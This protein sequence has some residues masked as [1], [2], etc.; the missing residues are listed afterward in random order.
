MCWVSRLRC[1]VSKFADIVVHAYL[2]HYN[3]SPLKGFNFTQTI[4]G[5]LVFGKYRGWMT[6]LLGE[7]YYWTFENW[8]CAD[9]PLTT[10]TCQKYYSACILI[11]CNWSYLFAKML[12][13]RWYQ[14]LKNYLSKKHVTYFS[15]LFLLGQ[16][17][18][19]RLHLKSKVSWKGYTQGAEGTYSPGNKGVHFIRQFSSYSQKTNQIFQ[20]FQNICTE[21]RH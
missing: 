5:S 15:L 17:I 2:T 1:K 20:N 10:W 18:Q 8:W 7:M 6:V 11:D 12:N 9:V 19:I 21:E 14:F 16:K 4:T 3:F 13:H